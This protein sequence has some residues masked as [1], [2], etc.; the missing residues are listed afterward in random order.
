MRIVGEIRERRRRPKLS[1]F[2]AFYK[3]NKDLP[4]AKEEF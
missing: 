1:D 4:N 2:L 3:K